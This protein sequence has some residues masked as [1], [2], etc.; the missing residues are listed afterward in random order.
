MLYERERHEAL[1]DDAWDEGRARE[2]IAAIVADM[3]NAIGDDTTW[4]AHPLDDPGDPPGR[5]KSLY[6]GSAGV[7]WALWHLRQRGFAS[8]RL[9]LGHLIMR[10]YE[11][12][13]AQPDMGEVVPS[14]FLGE[15]GILAAAFRMTGAPRFADRL[16][17]V[18]EGNVGHPTNEAL[19][20]APGTM[21]AALHM[22]DWTRDSA[23]RKLVLANVEDLWSSWRRSP[24]APCHLWT[25]DLYG[26]VVQLVGAGH[27]F[28]GNAYPLLRAAAHLAPE[29]RETL[30][31]RCVETLRAT[32]RFEHGTANWPQGVG[33]PRP[34]RTQLLVQ[35]CHGAPGI[36]T[37]LA[38]FPAAESAELDAMLL[39]A[40][41]TVWEAGPLAKGFGICH[42]TA[43]NGLAF[44]ALHHRSGAEIWL[45]RARRFA[46]HAI[47]Q[48]EAMRQHHGRGRF[49]LWTGDAGLALYLAQCV[50]EKAG[51]PTLDYL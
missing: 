48:Y 31:A 9:D 33:L 13:L 21:T 46:M 49:T 30:Y 5:Y 8:P 29:R 47:R 7:L 2:C 32:G 45:E 35:W 24:H 18:V 44:L 19:W 43:G 23:W 50:E 34:G 12:Y 26:N 6:L 28:A 17:A 1:A 10:T 20:G 16:A 41:A 15:A 36:V 51:V 3:E 14:Y 27:G 11:A 25:Q 38:P 4:P 39:Q 22:L 40:G 37:S 42:G